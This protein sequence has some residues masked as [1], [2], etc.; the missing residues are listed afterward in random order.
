M[1]LTVSTH[2]LCLH[3]AYTLLTLCSASDT[4]WRREGMPR[5]WQGSCLTSWQPT[6]AP[7]F[8]RTMKARPGQHGSLRL[9]LIIRQQSQRERLELRS[10][11]IRL[12]ADFVARPHSLSDPTFRA[13]LE[14]ICTPNNNPALDPN[15]KTKEQLKNEADAQARGG[16][17]TSSLAP[18]AKAQALGQSP[19]RVQPA[20]VSKDAA[21]K[22]IDE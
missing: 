7:R 13:S 15:N 18:K 17:T 4:S 2:V 21:N 9:L 8:R 5:A 3:S 10:C 1:I 22:K 11:F 12:E 14:Q 19:S 20:R 6:T 16:K